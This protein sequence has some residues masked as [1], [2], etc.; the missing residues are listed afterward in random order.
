M[1]ERST[2]PA[3]CTVDDMMLKLRH[4]LDETG[5]ILSTTKSEIQPS[6]AAL[7]FWTKLNTVRLTPSLKFFSSIAVDRDFT[8]G[9]IYVKGSESPW[10][11]RTPAVQVLSFVVSRIAERFELKRA[12]IDGTR[13]IASSDNHVA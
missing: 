2:K 1:S 12:Y 13:R 8:G 5:P 10:I 6:A 3:Y 4:D 7:D 11:C 9:G